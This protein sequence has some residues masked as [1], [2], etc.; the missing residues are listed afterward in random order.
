MGSTQSKTDRLKDIII[1]LHQLEAIK[2]GEFKLK[3]GI[4]S[5]VYFDLR[6]MVS[7]PKLMAKISRIMWDTYADNKSERKAELICGVPYTA[8]GPAYLIS[9]DQNIPSIIKRKEKKEYGT[10]KMLEGKFEVGQ[11][12]LIIE[13]VISSGASVL[14]TAEVLKNE[15]L[16]VTDVVVFLDR[17]Q[18]GS[19]N[20][21]NQNVNVHSVTNVTTLLQIL[22]EVGKITDEEKEKVENFIQNNKLT[23]G[24]GS[25]QDFPS[26]D[27]NSV[28]KMTIKD[29]MNSDNCNSSLAKQL[30]GIMDE[31]NTNL[32]L[33]ADVNTSQ[34]LFDLAEKTGRFICCLKTHID[35]LSDWHEN[36]SNNA[37]KLKEIAQ[38][39]D[40]LIFE[41]RK[42]ADIGKTV[43]AQFNC[44]PYAISSWADLVTVHG[45]PGPGILDGLNH[46]EKRCKALIVAEMSSKGNLASKEYADNCVELAK[47]HENAIGV[48]SQSRLD[49]TKPDLI[50]M[51]PGVKIAGIEDNLGQQY[52]TPEKAVIEKGADIIIVGRGITEAADPK[53]KA[54]EYQERGWRALLQRFEKS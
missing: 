22:F 10:K 48:I 40:F 53:E 35:A 46:K 28:Q 4:M 6:V 14:E 3:S 19:T 18:G 51:T 2:F 5:P 33:A 21:K 1:E 24:T 47:N 45:L 26:S 44:E 49:D 17:E 8:S 38:K 52:N 15:K 16:E 20:L 31:K 42:F 25:N 50:H 9:L 13:D 32:C 43:E 7:E 39:F 37:I 41:D 12:C 11:N 27:P 30:F 29:R 34:E 23:N 54:K 36:S